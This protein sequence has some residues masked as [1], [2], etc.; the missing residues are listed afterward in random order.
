M[1][2]NFFVQCFDAEG[3]KID[4]LSQSSHERDLQLGLEG[5]L[6]REIDLTRVAAIFVSSVDG[7]ELVSR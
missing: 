5:L 7:F 4:E 6:R 2:H 1:A 3:K